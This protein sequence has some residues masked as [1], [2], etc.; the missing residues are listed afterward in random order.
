MLIWSVNLNPLRL[1]ARL[2]PAEMDA[3]LDQ[4]LPRLEELGVGMVRT[5]FLWHYLMPEPRKADPAAILWMQSFV[6][7]LADAGIG[8]YGILYNPPGWACELAHNDESA[9]L[10]AW[11]HYVALCGMEFGDS[12]AVWQVWN[13]P[14]NYF[15]HVKD[16]FNLFDVRRMKVAGWEF[17]MPIR[18]R[19]DALCK[20]YRYARAELGPVPRIA[21]NFLSNMGNFAPVSFPDWIEWDV[22]LERTMERLHDD[23]DV[24]AMDHYPDTWVPGA[25]PLEWEPLSVLLR[26]IRDPRSACFGKAAVI[27]ELGYS[28]CANP[29]LPLGIRFFP[30]DHTEA[31]MA[32]WYAHALPFVADQVGPANLP[33][34]N[35]HML[36]LYE[37]VDAEPDSI[38]GQMNL[39]DIE[40]H[41]GLLRHDGS[42]KAAFDVVKKVVAGQ[43]AAA[44]QGDWGRS[45]PMQVYLE[46]SRMSRGFH[47][48]L[49]PKAVALYKTVTPP[50][51]RP[52]DRLVVGLGALWA[53]YHTFRRVK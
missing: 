9:F 15:S 38:G 42:P 49:G 29:N 28:S 37:L 20:L 24:L 44:T 7:R 35:F 17:D 50:M 8:T 31:R 39:V 19:W 18:V 26:K 25:G 2:D 22:F 14:N 5:D 11:R 1:S 33:G 13:E 10:E 3:R 27:G 53:L 32:D 34:Q 41:F 36:N 43:G 45:G 40:Y 4:L 51:H 48:W 23:I 6:G 30:E 47:R 12:V 21:T 46:A 16:D 52:G